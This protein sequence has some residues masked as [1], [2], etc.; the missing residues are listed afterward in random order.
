M[1]KTAEL[2]NQFKQET[3]CDPYYPAYQDWLEKRLSQFQQAEPAKDEWISVKTRLPEE[4]GFYLVSA[5]ELDPI[6]K[7]FG[8]PSYTNKTKIIFY[9]NERNV[10]GWQKDWTGEPHNVTHWM[11]LPKA[12]HKD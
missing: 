8:T 6:E 2:R 10:I 11:P 5:S 12:P 3:G 4:A 7:V 9:F 1:K